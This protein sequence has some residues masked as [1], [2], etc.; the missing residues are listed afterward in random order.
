MRGFYNHA[1]RPPVRPPMDLSRLSLPDA[2]TLAAWA[3]ALPLLALAVGRAPWRA[4]AAGP[5]AQ[6]WPASVAALV[7]LWSIR[8]SAEPHFAF[9]LSGIAALAL[10][11]GPWLALVGGAIVVAVTF[12]LGGAPWANAGLAWLAGVAVPAGAALAILRAAERRLPPNFFVYAIVVAFFG[13]AVSYLATGLAGAAVL[14]TALGVP[15]SLAFG[16]Y[17]IYVGTLA[18]GEATLTGM[19]ISLA[20]VYRPAWVATFRADRYF[21]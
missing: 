10:S 15:P 11:S 20:A 21:R 1:P 7:A 18:F 6:V 12:A 9:H 4:L 19:L 5:G 13:G 3:V 17:L 8:G 16:D 14:V 2:W